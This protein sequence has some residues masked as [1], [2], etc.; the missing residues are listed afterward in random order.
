MELT[1]PDVGVTPSCLDGGMFEIERIAEDLSRVVAGMDPACLDGR[2]AA[3]LTEVA[4]EGEKLFGAAK[5][6][7]ARRAAE[8]R[9]WARNSLATTPEQW[10]AKAS[11]CTE[12]AARDV[13][14]TA[15]RLTE[16]PA[17]AEKLRGGRGRR[18]SRGARANASRMTH[19]VST[20]WSPP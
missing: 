8:T 5:A 14:A 9:A 6:L 4:A 20:R 3:R 13:L 10:L 12:G 1:R 15:Q 11:G 18:R 7:L 16:L 17:T 19:T 2:D